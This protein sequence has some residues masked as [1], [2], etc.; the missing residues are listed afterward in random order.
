MLLFLDPLIR[1]LLWTCDLG[2]FLMCLVSRLRAECVAVTDDQV[3]W[4]AL[5]SMRLKSFVHN[6]LV[7][8][9][10]V[11]VVG[12]HWHRRQPQRL[13]L[14]EL[15]EARL[16]SLR[17][18]DIQCGIDWTLFGPKIVCMLRLSLRKWQLWYPNG[19]S[20]VQT[21]V[22]YR[23]HVV[24]CRPRQFIQINRESLIRLIYW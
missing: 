13:A 12:V 14:E 16:R 11:V 5:V 15:I 7:D 1:F 17:L 10:D 9:L 6:V 3:D 23:K 20:T 19:H 18:I 22:L 4:L 24:F 2:R 21:R 8:L